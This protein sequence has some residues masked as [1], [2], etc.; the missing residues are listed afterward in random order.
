MLLTEFLGKRR[1]HDNTALAGGSVEVRLA[2]LPARR[3]EC[4]SK[5]N[6]SAYI[7]IFAGH[8]AAM[9]PLDSNNP[10]PQGAQERQ[11]P[12]RLDGIPKTYPGS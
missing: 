11:K 10:N 3:G 6:P 2:R 9:P 8:Q 1:A 4:Y 7:R 5:E 12:N